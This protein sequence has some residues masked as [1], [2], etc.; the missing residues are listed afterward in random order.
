MNAFIRYDSKCKV[1]SIHRKLQR[2]GL[3]KVTKIENVSINELNKA[4]KLQ[5]KSID[6][7]KMISTLRRIKNFKKLTKEDLIVTLL[8]SESNALENNSNNNDNNDK[9]NNDKITYIK[10]VLRIL[11]NTITNKDRKKIKK[12]LYEIE[13]SKNLLDTEK[14]KS[15]DNLVKLVRTLDKK[16]KYQYQDYDDLD[17]YGIK[18]IENLFDS[19]DID[20]Y[21][22]PILIKSSFK[23]NYK[24]YE[25]KGDKSKNLSVRQYLHNITQYLSDLINNHKTNENNSSEWKIQ[26]NM[27]IKF[28]ASNDTR[29][30]C[31]VYP[32]SDHEEVR[33]GNDTHDIAINLFNSF[34]TNY[35]NEETILGNGSNFAF[36]SVNFLKKVWKKKKK[37]IKSPQSLINKKSTIN[38]KHNDD[39]FFQYA[40]TVTLNHKKMENIRKEYRILNLL[41]INILGKV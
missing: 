6:E 37:Y 23:N 5:G 27:S 41:L 3:E 8:K 30:I 35:R 29:E 19:I 4:E 18:D 25:S 39:K 28:I 40:I 22:K 2:L 32:W 16:E 21:Y 26:L 14:E 1:E 11:G 36:K 12:E 13:K 15:Y 34:L 33:S 31:T 38:P 17:Y 9:N 20:D 7:V 10:M 24:V